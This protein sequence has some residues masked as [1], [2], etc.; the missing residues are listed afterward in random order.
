MMKS[1]NG[2]N[3]EKPVKVCILSS[4]HSALDVRVF[5][6]EARTLARAGYDV[7]LI[8][9]HT[10]DETID[11]VKIIA[12]P[13]PRNR[14][15]RMMWLTL[16]AFCLA[17]EQK[18]DI[19]HFH[20]PEL[21]F[22]G[23]LLKLFTRKKV[24]YEVHEDWPHEIRTREWIPPF[25]RTVAAIAFCI[26]ERI[27]AKLMDGI[28]LAGEGIHNL[29][30]NKNVVVHNYP[31]LEYFREPKV[32]KQ[33]V[34][35]SDYILIF[36]GGLV[37]IRGIYEMI[38]AMEFIS[39]KYRIKLRLLGKFVNKDTEYQARSLRG[40]SYVE[41]ID[42]VSYKDIPK[43]LAE[44]DIGLILFHPLPGHI[45]SMP[46]KLFEYMAAGLPVI[47]SNFPLWKEIVEGNKCGLTVDPL[48]PKEIA[49]AIEY[50][51]EHPEL[52]QEMGENGRRAVIEKYNWEQEA[53]KLLALYQRLLERARD[54]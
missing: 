35:S 13:R 16:K 21:L 19:Y 25:L 36:V 47:A 45:K 12:L 53:E 10:R 6:K 49:Q 48:N 40:F 3:G 42:W 4:V 31:P 9:Q 52:R 54:S 14:L 50:L 17:L 5:H 1:S 8:A 41:L 30:Y 26:L 18:A 51:L 24:I 27:C 33:F 15:Q 32:N 43:Y 28:I 29:S 22:I 20:P 46:N 37:R 23:V 34:K 38:N 2:K 39:S 11:G 7:T 44:A